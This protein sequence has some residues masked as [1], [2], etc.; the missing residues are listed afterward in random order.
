VL[1]T[2]QPAERFIQ[3]LKCILKAYNDGKSIHHRLAKFL[4]D[5]R[6]TPHATTY[7][8]LCELFLQR[9]LRT[10]FDLMMPNTKQQVMSKQATE[11]QHHD[12]YS[13]SQPKFPGTTVYA[14]E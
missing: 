6:A 14:R 2:I 3:T 13:R 7:I 10:C 8:T 9:K 1:L 5:Y 11:K 4:F 12:Q